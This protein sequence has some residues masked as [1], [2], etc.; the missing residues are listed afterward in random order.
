MPAA[1]TD[2]ISE[3]MAA[4]T[5]EAAT[6]LFIAAPGLDVAGGAAGGA[7][8]TGAEAGGAATGTGEE[9]AGM[10]TRAEGSV[11]ADVDAG[12]GAAEFAAESELMYEGI[13]ALFIAAVLEACGS[14]ALTRIMSRLL[15]AV[16]SMSMQVV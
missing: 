14:K 11:A 8:F 10:D 6:A 16:T 12:V 4:S 13:A 1:N 2:E 5:I 9:A 7:E 3:L 15:A